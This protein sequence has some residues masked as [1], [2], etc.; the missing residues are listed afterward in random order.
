MVVGS[1]QK[2]P[3]RTYRNYVRFTEQMR[4]EIDDLAKAEGISFGSMVLV[5]VNEA[6]QKRNLPT[7]EIHLQPRKVFNSRRESNLNRSY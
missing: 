3:L 4:K 2:R 7:V 5:L 1:H 6:F